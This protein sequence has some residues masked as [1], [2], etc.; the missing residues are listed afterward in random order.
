M[1]DK[2]LLETIRV[3]ENEIARA[4]DLEFAF[5]STFGNFGRFAKVLAAVNTNFVIGGTL[6]KG[7]GWNFRVE[8]VVGICA[9]NQQIAFNSNAYEMTIDKADATN[10][11]D[12]LFI[13]GI[14]NPEGDGPLTQRAFKEDSAIITKAIKIKH[15]QEIEYI[16]RRGDAGA[17][18]AKSI[19][20]EK[21]ENVIKIAEIFVPAGAEN[22]TQ[23]FLHSVN[24]DLY[25]ETNEGWTN[26]IDDTM[27]LHS[28]LEFQEIIRT[29]HNKDGSL[30]NGI[31]SANNLNL[32]TGQ[33]EI[34]LNTF[35][36]GTKM[37]GKTKDNTL[38]QVIDA[39]ESDIGSKSP[40]GHTH[41]SLTDGSHVASMPSKDGTLALTSD[42]PQNLLKYSAQE[43][44][45]SDKER[46]RLNID[47]AKSA[48]SHTKAD[49]TDFTHSHTKADITDFPSSL[50]ASDVY[51]WAKAET[52]PTY[53][54]SEIG[55]AKEEHKHTAYDINNLG[56]E[57]LGFNFK[58]YIDICSNK[59]ITANDSVVRAIYRAAALTIGCVHFFPFD[60]SGIISE[61]VTG[62]Y[63]VDIKI[64]ELVSKDNFF[65][66]AGLER[67]YVN[68]LYRVTNKPLVQVN[69]IN[70]LER[71]VDFTSIAFAGAS[72]SYITKIP[73][74]E[75]YRYMNI[76]L[77]GAPIQYQICML[78]HVVY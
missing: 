6:K 69:F 14:V 19:A 39:M 51:D 61:Q 43:L 78:I 45:D 57:P 16:L 9:N 1:S 26:N 29:C 11:I 2:D 68:I 60:K 42:I 21:L 15:V 62:R 36:L 25:G 23:C 46:A 35:A 33:N 70:D 31:V 18:T 44:P 53:T 30:K 65:N 73:A 67:T 28:L 49:I 74:G 41:S 10:R 76:E 38:V 55:A 40:N 63:I 8:P 64:S 5:K 52:K 54:T 22:I 66:L 7:T 4:D 59:V 77:N 32:G 56:L 75:V 37:Y 72:E 71:S 47:A 13:K 27:K 3:E 17:K 50:P 20:E 24:R 34:N 48:H 58:D 12:T